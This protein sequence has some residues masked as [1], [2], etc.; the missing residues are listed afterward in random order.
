MHPNSD[1]DA[2]YTPMFVIDFSIKNK[3]YMQ[4]EI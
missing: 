2:I 4:G 1:W 3:S